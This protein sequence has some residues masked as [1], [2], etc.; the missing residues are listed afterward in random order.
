MVPKHFGIEQGIF[1]LLD[2]FLLKVMDNRIDNVRGKGHA[3][4]T[5]TFFLIFRFLDSRVCVQATTT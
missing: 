4:G 1:T 3:I 5:S 2:I